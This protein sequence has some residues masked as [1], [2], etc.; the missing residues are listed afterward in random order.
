MTEARRWLAVLLRREGLNAK[1]FT[2]HSLRK[3]GFSFA[4]LAGADRADLQALGGWRSWA[5]N[6]YLPT[7]AERDRAAAAFV[8]G[9]SHN[10]HI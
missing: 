4:F 1:A 7:D 10:L 8:R 5:S 3:G 2:F 6:A 9:A